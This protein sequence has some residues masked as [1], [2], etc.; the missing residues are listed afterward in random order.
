MMKPLAQQSG[1][2]LVELLMAL[3]LF[4]FVLLIITMGF[5]QVIHTYQA[6]IA[7]RSTQQTTRFG[8]D[9]MA[10]GVRDAS[11]VGIALNTTGINDHPD[12]IVQQTDILC[13]F[14]SGGGAN[15]R[16]Y[17]KWNGSTKSLVK[18][19]FTP[20]INLATHT[21]VCNLANPIAGTL[22]TLSS[23]DLSIQ[24]FNAEVVGIN[25]TA[26]TQTVR[27]TLRVTSN[28]RDLL[29]S[30]GNVGSNCKGAVGGQFCSQTVITTTVEPRGNIQ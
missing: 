22:Q 3:A 15:T 5:I 16:Y 25:A 20:A 21:P 7:S 11:T 1:F 27:L 24:D 14:S 10:R 6:G 13:A 26:P 29:A 30:P 2:T 18:E 4:S 19:Y 8:M 23:S 9:D 28:R 12:G 17:V